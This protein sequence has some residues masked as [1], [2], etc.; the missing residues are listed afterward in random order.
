MSADEIMNVFS[1]SPDF[2]ESKS[3]YQ[4]DHITGEISGTVYSPPECS[5][6]KSYGICF[7]EDGLCRKEWMTHPL[8][9]YK[10]KDKSS[11]KGKKKKKEEKDEP[12]QDRST[13]QP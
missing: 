10:V 13:P 6:M 7:N 1:A 9:Y 12:S 3:R 5:T 11:K 4:I 8:K 2:D